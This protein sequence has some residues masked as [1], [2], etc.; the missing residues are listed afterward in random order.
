M[1]RLAP[2]VVSLSFAA[3]LPLWGCDLPSPL[4][5]PSGEMVLMVTT[6]HFDIMPDTM[7]ITRDQRLAF[8]HTGHPDRRP[9]RAAHIASDVVFAYYFDRDPEIF[10][11]IRGGELPHPDRSLWAGVPRCDHIAIL[12]PDSLMLLTDELREIATRVIPCAEELRPD[13]P[14]GS[15]RECATAS[16]SGRIGEHGPGI[17]NEPALGCGATCMRPTACGWTWATFVKMDGYKRPWPEPFA[18]GARVEVEVIC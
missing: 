7:R 17:V 9:P 6:G 18:G 8:R 12:E 1:S 5:P 14:T 11:C 16:G 3:L 13:S 10:R 15:F 2:P 4:S